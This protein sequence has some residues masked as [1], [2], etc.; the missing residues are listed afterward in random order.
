LTSRCSG[1]RLAQERK[2]KWFEISKK[3]TKKN[4]KK[5]EEKRMKKQDFRVGVL[6]PRVRDHGVE[7]SGVVREEARGGGHGPAEKTFVS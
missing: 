6:S 5:K 4:E 7:M 1:E 3:Q 2:R